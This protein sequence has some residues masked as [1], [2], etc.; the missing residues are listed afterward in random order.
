MGTGWGANFKLLC[1]QSISWWYIFIF[2]AVHVVPFQALDGFDAAHHSPKLGFWIMMIRIKKWLCF[3]MDPY[4]TNESIIQSPWLWHVPRLL[5]LLIMCN[6]LKA[7][8]L[9]VISLK[10]TL[11]YY[12]TF[13]ILS[14]FKGYLSYLNNLFKKCYPYKFLNQKY[15]EVIHYIFFSLLQ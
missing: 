2:K 14:T 10:H 13:N 6:T 7:S 5:N 12:I 9:V 15:H 1:R 8:S 3:P 4:R 11:F